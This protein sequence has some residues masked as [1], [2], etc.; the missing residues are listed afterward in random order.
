MPSGD[1]TSYGG[2]FLNTNPQIFRRDGLLC[3][4]LIGAS[5]LA[6][7]P[8]ADMGFQDDWSYIRT[9]L[10][11][12][13]TGH[14]VYNGWAT[15]MLGWM[16]PWGA[17]FI[18]LFG[19]SFT[20]VRLSTLPIA[21]VTTYLLH[22]CMVRCG[23]ARRN[24]VL[25]T[26]TFGL[27]PVFT[28]MAASFMTDVH[29]MFVI[30][31]CA[32]LCLRAIDAPSTRETL[33]WL[34]CAAL[35]NVLGGTVRQIAWLGALVMVPST[36]A[37]LRR[38]KGVLSYA[39][40]LWVLSFAGILGCLRWWANQPYSVPERIDRGSI[41]A[42]MVHHFGGRLVKGLLCLL[43][44][45][46]PVLAAWFGQI[47]QLSRRA[48]LR[49]AGLVALILTVLL[50][51]DVGA[52]DLWV[53]PWIG[54]LL[55]SVIYG[56]GEFPGPGPVPISLNTRLIVSLFVVATALIFIERYRTISSQRKV[57][58]T[59]PLARSWREA[60]WVFGP[61]S[62]A[63]ILLLLPRAMYEF[64]YDRYMLGIMPMAMILLL[65]L[66][67]RWFSDRV[68]ALTFAVLALFAVVSVAGTHDWFAVNRARVLA[69]E[70]LHTAGIPKT[71]IQGGFEYDGWTEITAA[72]YVNEKRITVPAGA[73][74]R[75]AG[76]ALPHNCEHFFSAMA[77]HVHPR[78]VVVGSP[79]PC[80]DPSSFPSVD[81]RAWMPPFHRSVFVQ[82]V[83]DPAP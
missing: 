83:R 76:L 14:F 11:F 75:F 82:K 37:Y 63:Y 15:A 70:E 36:A 77:A 2:A 39:T 42:S 61:F 68:P 22:S 8:Y 67:Q 57:E 12:A 72:G 41:D 18:K 49:V 47:P 21:M 6:T 38:R 55:Y 46:Y 59:A 30:L 71:A 10:E 74:H 20:S 27:S 40:F 62:I 56:R 52:R 33:F 51:I 50:Q 73:Y 19:F 1:R 69:V 24:A 4:V 54:H 64:L 9:A 29:G 26:L 34:T 60:L 80:F 53:F 31:L 16:I 48:L 44:L 7:C 5:V 17:F 66:Y 45:I 32:W 3:A 43:L 25:G 79:L 78:Y 58:R 35:S 65:R 13:R 23:V 28:P 81:Y